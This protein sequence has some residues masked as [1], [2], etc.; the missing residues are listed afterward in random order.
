MLKHV[1]IMI[2]SVLFIKNVSAID[3]YYYHGNRITLNEREDRIIIIVNDRDEN[4][5]FIENELRSALDKNDVLKNSYSNT[6]EVIFKDV[7]G[8]SKVQSYINKFSSK[9]N[10]IKFVSPAYY[11]DNYKITIICPDEFILKLKKVSDVSKLELL[12]MQ[13]GVQIIKSYPGSKQ[14]LLKTFNGNSK[15]SLELSENYFSSGLFEYCEPNFLY[16]DYCE[17][18]SDPNDPLFSTQWN[19]KNTGQTIT[20]NTSSNGVDALTYKGLAGSDMKVNLAWDVTTG[21]PSVEIGILDT[22]I[23]ST[24]PDLRNNLLTGYDATTDLNS[25]VTDP[26]FHGTCTAGIIGAS[27]NN[28]LG[29]AGVAYNCR[30]RSYQMFNTSGTSSVDYKVAAFNKAKNYGAA[31]LSNSWAGGNASNAITDAIDSCGIYGNSGKGCVILFS[32]GNE[33]RNPP[34]YPSWIPSVVAVGASTANDQ[35]KAPSNGNQ[36]FWGGDYGESIN[37]DIELVAPTIQPSTDIQGAG[38]YNSAAGSAGDYVSNFNGTSCSC[39]NA[40]GVAGLI[41]S[42]NNSLTA[43]QVRSYLLKGCDKID[44][45]S[46]NTNKTYGQWNEYFGYGRVNAYNSVK[47][48]QG[49][50]IIP[51]TIVHENIESGNSTYPVTILADIIDVGGGTVDNTSAKV[52]YRSNKNNSGWSVFDTLSSISQLSNTFTF[53]IPGFG[54]ETQVQYYITA[55]DNFN[56]RAYFPIHAPD[57][58]NLCYYAIGSLQ[59]ITQKFGSVV[60]PNIGGIYTTV[61]PTFANFKIVKTKVRTYVQDVRLGDLSIA[62]QS[63][64]SNTVLRSKCVFSQNASGITSGI[65]N[66]TAVDSAAQYWNAGV[67]PFTGGFYKP[68]YSFRGLNGLNAA[69][70]WKLLLYDSRDDGFNATLDSAFITLY[71]TSGT[72]SSSVVINSATDSIA[73]FDGASTDTV[74]F[75]MKNHGTGNLTISAVVF[76]GTYASKFTLISSLPGPIVPNDSGLFKVRCDPSAPRPMESNPVTDD[77]ENATMDI[78]TND[79]SKPVVKISLQTPAP[80]P[81]ELSSFISIVERN[82]VNLKWTTSFEMNNSGFEIERRSK[83]IISWEK[84]GNVPGSGSINS[85]VNYSFTD[86]NVTTGKYSYKL[87]QIDFNGAF[88]YYDLSD[89]VVVGI[90]V[91]FDLSQNYPNPFNPS[92][93]INY[94]L[95][96]ESKVSLKIYDMTGREVANLVNATQLAGYYVIQFNVSNLASGIYFYNLIAEGSGKSFINTKKM[97]LLK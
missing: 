28:A 80:L 41:F 78:S 94:D 73:A 48:A 8:L 46:Y 91:K 45:V 52:I 29:V 47:L 58:T 75:Y 2:F 71:K 67:Q 86:K 39:P 68:D 9:Q 84:V 30:I 97:V 12:N 6:Y 26:G 20:A 88:K 55:K 21:S 5:L 87:K 27:G 83:G 4:K 74:N 82:N 35:K 50:D 34:Q 90:P 62:L 85:P 36:F 11:T 22:G 60:V 31:V 57:S 24:H 92:T 23:D 77:L 72:L 56:N 40:A 10:I 7:F 14:F 61:N 25:V 32:T 13:N 42:I 66:A 69:G 81:V 54:W 38:G 59:S 49:I 93:K 51:P 3:Y 70:T 63:P 76:N 64:V 79:P 43:A 89:E 19:L 1:S 37:G 95:P 65:T 96:F 33:G 18:T 17:L 53:K 15:T 16:P 44:N